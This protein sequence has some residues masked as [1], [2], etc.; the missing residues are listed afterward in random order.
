[1]AGEP[2]QLQLVKKSLKKRE[3]LKLLDRHFFVKPSDVALDLGCAQGILSFF[4]RQKGGTWLSADLDFVNCQ[5]A[6]SLLGKNCLQIGPDSLPFKEESFDKVVSLDYL[7][8]LEDDSGCLREVH[9]ILKANG[10]LVLA[11]PRTGKIFLLHKLRSAMGMKLEFYGHKREGYRLL[12][13]K[14]KLLNTGFSP[15]YN[16]SFSR[17]FSEFLE[18]VLNLFYIRFYRPKEPIGL[19]DGHIRPTTAEEFSSRKKAFRLYSFIYPLIWLFT[20]LDALFFL[21]RGYGLMIWAR[22]NKP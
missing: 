5:T 22:K 4:L 10:E 20:R 17:F 3:K 14:K 12:D 7:E 1:M 6:Q 9:R 16:K 2:W 18:L 15:L 13:L 8:H 21:Q 19:R 11:T